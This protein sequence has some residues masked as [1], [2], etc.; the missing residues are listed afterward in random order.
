MGRQNRSGPQEALAQEAARLICEERLIDYRAA[1][2]KALQRLGLGPHT[3][4]PDN[5][6]VRD[7]VLEYQ[8]LF[9]GDEYTAHL[10]ALR[11]TALQAINLLAEFQP[12]LVGGAVSGAV[13]TAHRVQLHAFSEKPESLDL[14]LQSH[15]IPFEQDERNYRY[16]DGRERTIP[17]ACFEAGDIGVDV[18]MFAIDDQ[19]HAPLDPAEGVAYKRLDLH[20]AEKLGSTIS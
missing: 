13:T 11:R 5:A 1:K 8:Q 6:H 3:P 4:L 16:S 12:R 7:A 18:A 15:G 20:A 10:S 2:L 19:R 14:F 17:L 9:G